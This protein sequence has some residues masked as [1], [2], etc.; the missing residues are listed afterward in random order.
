MAVH[1]DPL[2]WSA[3]PGWKL[4]LVHGD[5]LDNAH[6]RP[7]VA[8]EVAAACDHALAR[9]SVAG[10]AA[11]PGFAPWRAL[12]PKDCRPAHEAL[13]RRVLSGK[14]LPA[15]NPLV[16]LYNARS[17]A[18]CAPMGAWDVDGLAGGDLRLFRTHGGEPFTALGGSE[19]VPADPGEIAYGDAEV[20]VTHHFV[21]RQ[22]ERAKVTS[23]TR[24]FVLVSEVVPGLGSAAA[25]E[26]LATTIALLREHFAL[27]CRGAVLAE[28]AEHWDG[29]A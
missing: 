17:V 5:G 6:P 8:R 28:P 1:V 20:L 22:A 11:H 4:V 24:R 29:D 27:E 10:L 26:I 13:L 14:P 9:V 2:V 21:W 25:D 23:E 18:H 3:V 12:L 15:I 16:D 19:T 7:G